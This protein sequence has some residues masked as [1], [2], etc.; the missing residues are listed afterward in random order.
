VELSFSLPPI[1]RE[2]ELKLYMEAEGRARFGEILRIKLIP[3]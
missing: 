2:V 3:K 1:D